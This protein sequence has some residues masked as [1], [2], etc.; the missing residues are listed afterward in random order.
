MIYF[1]FLIALS[2]V[3]GIILYLNIFIKK[4]LFN[5]IDVLIYPIITCIFVYNLLF[6]HIDFIFSFQFYFG[7]ILFYSFFKKNKIYNFNIIFI[8]VTVFIWIEFLLINTVISPEL[9]PNHPDLSAS[10]HHSTNVIF[11]R[12]Y[13]FGCNASV[14]SSLFV[15][16]FYLTSDKFKNFLTHLLFIITITIF[17]SGTGM[18]CLAIFYFSKLLKLVFILLFLIP[19]IYYIHQFP[20]FYKISY[21]Y[22]AILLDYK[23][24]QLSMIFEN[25]VFLSFLFGDIDGISL[26]A[27]GSDFGWPIFVSCYGI[28]GLF[29]VL[30]IIFYNINKSNFLPIF[31]LLISTFHYPT[32]FFFTDQVFLGYL[33]NYKRY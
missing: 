15:V 1:S 13:S 30:S 2:P 16:I 9:L 3:I 32:I 5:Q 29:I 33:L 28:I 21:E 25:Y 10:S 18:I 23:L 6:S 24:Y 20:F 14:S 27:Y 4:F 17:M 7:F 31:I 8:I 12:P 22:F 19:L 11:N 26:E